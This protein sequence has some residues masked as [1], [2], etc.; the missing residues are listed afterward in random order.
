[1]SGVLVFAGLANIYTVA[2]AVVWCCSIFF[3]FMGEATGSTYIPLLIWSYGVATGPWSYMASKEA[4]NDEGGDGS[5]LIAFSIEFAFLIVIVVSLFTDPSRLEV[6]EIF[7]AVMAVAVV[8][9]VALVVLT[10]SAD[11]Q[12]RDVEIERDFSKDANAEAPSRRI[13]KY[14]TACDEGFAQQ[15]QSGPNCGDSLESFEMKPI[16]H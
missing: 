12:N 6:I 9:Q 3:H 2:L 16:G 11:R 1:M 15:F 14:C 5:P 7:G 4:S 13:V 8:A 10:S